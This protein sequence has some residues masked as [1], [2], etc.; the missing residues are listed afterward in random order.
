MERVRRRYWT[1]AVTLFAGT[2]IFAA[3][4]SG[5]FQL[6]VLALPSYREEI[7]AW[8]TRV[9][10]RPVDIGGINLVWRGVYPRLDLTDITL[11]DEDGSEALTADRVSLGFSTARLLL[12]ELMPTRIE[13]NGLSIAAD[14]DE[15]GQLSVAGFDALGGQAFPKNDRLIK[16]LRRFQRVR[17]SNCEVRF[18]HAGLGRSPAEFTLVAGEID[19]TRSGF[20]AEADIRL[21]PVYGERVELA[22]SIDGDVADPRSWSGDFSAELRR[23]APQAWIRNW[24]LPGAQVQATDLTLRAKGELGQGRLQKMQLRAESDAF[25]V[26]RAGRAWQGKELDAQATVIAEDRGW[27][28]D[29]DRLEQDDQ[30]M[31]RGHLRYR[32]LEQQGYELDAD[33]DDLQLGQFTPWLAYL[34]DASPGLRRA[35]GLS[36]ELDGLVL[37]LRRAEDGLHYSLK[38]DFR[39]IALAGDPA[40]LAA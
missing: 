36:G 2:V 23:M 5:V 4:V 3:A 32:P 40:P 39:E 35:A 26:A 12:G 38:S 29:I 7:S 21:P 34:R 6:A 22:A 18:T 17:L 16:E 10:D 13:L 9:A 30:P 28:L 15:N 8:V 1:W 19:R 25:V 33:I 27:R 20:D 31:L 37:R 24:L 14:V 11:Y